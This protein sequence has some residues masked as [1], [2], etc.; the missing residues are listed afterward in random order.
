MRCEVTH[1]STADAPFLEKG[2]DDKKK[3]NICLEEEIKC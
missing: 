1:N 3:S 2:L